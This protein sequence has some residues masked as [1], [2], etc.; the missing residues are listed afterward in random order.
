M[1]AILAPLTPEVVNE[2]LLVLTPVTGAPKVNANVAVLA[3][4]YVW[5]AVIELTVVGDN[6]VLDGMLTSTVLAFALVKTILPE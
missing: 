2:K 6:T 1:D 5:F 3:F 4:E